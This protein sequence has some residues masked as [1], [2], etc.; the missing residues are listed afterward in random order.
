MR[1]RMMRAM[2]ASPMLNWLREQLAHRA[3]APV[4]EMIDVVRVAASRP[5][6]RRRAEKQQVLDDDDEVFAAERRLVVVRDPSASL[7]RT[8]R[9]RAA[10]LVRQLLVQLVAAHLRQVVALRD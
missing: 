4:A 6:L 5:A 7:R 1:S 8:S 9:P 2:R 3:H 10:G